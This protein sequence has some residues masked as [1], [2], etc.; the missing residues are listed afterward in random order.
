[1]ESLL[2]VSCGML[3]IFLLLC[4]Q[5]CFSFV[6]QTG[7]ETVEN[8]RKLMALSGKVK[9]HD[10]KIPLLTLTSPNLSGGRRQPISPRHSRP[11]VHLTAES[12]S[13]VSLS[14]IA[15]R[16]PSRTGKPVNS[17]CLVFVLQY[18]KKKISLQ[19]G[20]ERHTTLYGLLHAFCTSLDTALVLYTFCDIVNCTFNLV[21]LF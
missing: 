14:N 15:N 2:I 19:K 20:S 11:P 5:E 17:T 12:S 18:F 8:T 1:M 6:F 21:G 7:A 10:S 9:P 3:F 16:K 4:M 13:V